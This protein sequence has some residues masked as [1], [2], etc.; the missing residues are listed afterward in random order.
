MSDYKFHLMF[1]LGRDLRLPQVE[2]LN[3]YF[4]AELIQGLL[5]YYLMLNRINPSDTNIFETLTTKLRLKVYIFN[6]F[7]RH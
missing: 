1:L 3:H 4:Q 2:G 6:D 7:H 5:Q